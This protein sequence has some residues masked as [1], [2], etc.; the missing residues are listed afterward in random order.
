M[1]LDSSY[2][3]ASMTRIKIAAIGDVSTDWVFVSKEPAPSRLPRMRPWSRDISTQ[4][5]PIPGGAWFSGH[6]LQGALWEPPVFTRSHH[7]EIEPLNDGFSTLVSIDGTIDFGNAEKGCLEFGINGSKYGVFANEQSEALVD[8]IVRFKISRSIE[9]RKSPRFSLQLIA[10]RL[11]VNSESS[12]RPGYFSVDQVARHFELNN[13]TV[14]LDS[15]HQIGQLRIHQCKVTLVT[16]GKEAK[17]YDSFSIVGATTFQLDAGSVSSFPIRDARVS[18]QFGTLR[19]TTEL[20]DYG[21]LNPVHSVVTKG[22]EELT[23]DVQRTIPVTTKAGPEVELFMYARPNQKLLDPDPETLVYSLSE[24]RPFDRY[25]GQLNKK[26]KVYRRADYHGIAGPDVGN[27]QILDAYPKS[28]SKFFDQARLLSDFVPPNPE[29]E[30]GNAWKVGDCNRI[31]FIDD[32]G[33]GFTG[34]E[35]LWKMYFEL[36][37]DQLTKTWVIVK[38]SQWLAFDG[39]P[40]QAFLVNSQMMDRT[41]AVLSADSLRK[42]ILNDEEKPGIKLSKTVSWERSIEDFYAAFDSGALGSI[43]DCGHLI[44]RFGLEG[45]IFHSGKKFQL[46]F[47]K[48]RIENEYAPRSELGS[49]SGMTTVF[50]CS[51]TQSLVEWMRKSPTD[52]ISNMLPQAIAR[53]LECCRRF[54]DLGYGP[55]KKTILKYSALQLPISQVFKTGRIMHL[56]NDGRHEFAKADVTRL[57]K[58]KP[59][60][61]SL[62]SNGRQFR[63]K[64]LSQRRGLSSADHIDKYLDA[65]YAL[66]LGRTI[67]REGFEVA[68]SRSEWAFPFARFGQLVS[69]DR[70]E[71]EG[72]RSC[73]N[74]L[75]EYVSSHGRKTPLS[76]AV[77]G[78]PGCGKSF[79]VT[80]IA[81]T[82]A[83]AKIDEFVFNMAQ[84]SSFAEVTRLLL[85]V[86]DS[87]IAD[88]LPLVFFDEFDSHFENQTL[89]WLKYFL[90]PMHDGRFQHQNEMLSIG[91]AIFVFA[92]GLAFSHQEFKSNA[93]WD[94]STIPGSK[95]SAFRK[96]K[97][98][99]FHSRLRGFLDI[100]GPNPSI[101]KKRKTMHR[102]SESSNEE[103]DKFDRYSQVDFSYVVRRAVLIRQ[104]IERL[105]MSSGGGIID[106]D[107]QAAV[108]AD[109]LDALLLADCYKHGVRS[110]QAIFEM[111]NI[112][113]ER[114]LGKTALPSSS[115]LAMHVDDSFYD[116]LTRKFG[117]L[118][119]GILSKLL[120]KSSSKPS[121]GSSDPTRSIH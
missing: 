99:D 47:D 15:I 85:H 111:S 19:C 13:G 33:L 104:M 12:I 67:V 32:E 43:K 115:Q 55:S 119:S 65:Y 70:D 51:I 21:K 116:I 1:T 26:I 30:I 17:E 45:A 46:V 91:R 118:R 60:D 28:D 8:E 61:W 2:K 48:A 9:H 90:A 59:R 40:L 89:G 81:R 4:L 77:F 14:E 107:G 44:V 41:I 18:V 36:S 93:T 62:L 35:K 7:V 105:A 10:G 64:A 58:K 54:F 34:V 69:V 16:K 74:V 101:P 25:V 82:V 117:S 63:P 29:T 42:G 38:A 6:M 27:P 23:V 88:K 75:A 53:S 87:A 95:V 98:P 49:F 113:K 72:L 106:I 83:G 108:D 79:G 66:S 114:S 94:E 92:G 109:V 11:A 84:F 5:F 24:L 120:V 102:S 50:A 3:T 71:I 78:P 73:R 31:V 103:Q 110:I 68:I 22:K 97:G 80:Q 112:F 100:K 39:S 52:S 86:R 121:I 96:A 57:V 20:V 37:E 76:I 56:S